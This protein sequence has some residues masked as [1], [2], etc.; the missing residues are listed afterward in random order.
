MFN[1]IVRYKFLYRYYYGTIKTKLLKQYN[2]IT[3]PRSVTETQIK[4]E[5]KEE[6]KEEILSPA[7]PQATPSPSDSAT[8]QRSTTGKCFILFVFISVLNE[9]S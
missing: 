4:E 5:V 2:D 7:R 9:L 1:N 8:S 6:V 3:R